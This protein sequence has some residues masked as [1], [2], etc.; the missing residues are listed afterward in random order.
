MSNSKPWLKN[1]PL[2]VPQEI[3]APS[4]SSLADFFEECFERYANRQAVESMGKF[5]TYR[6]LDSLSQEFASY[7]RTLGL[8]R[9][10]RVALMYPNV[11]EY[12]I[13][14]IGTLRAGYTV[15]NINPLYTARELEAQLQDSGASVL[16]LMEN[17]A[18]TYQQIA[19]QVPL[20]QVIVSSPGELLGL[21]GHIV[22]WVARNIKKMVPPW[23]FD[24]V[25]FKEALRIGGQYPF[26][27]PVIGLDDIAFLQYTGGTTGTSK[28]AIL[29][30][31]NILSNVMQVETWLNPGLKHRNEQQLHFLCALPMTH[32]FALTACAFLGITKGALLVLVANPRDIDGFIKM[33]MK[34]PK[35]NIFP[36]VNTLFHAL[37]HRPEF[38]KVKLP[39]LLVT[40]G[41][42]MAVHKKTAD[43]WQ[44]IT[45]CSIAQG[46][47][48]SETSPVVC[49]NSPLEKHFT[50]HIG[51]PMPSTDVVILD[52]DEVELLQGTPGEICIKGPQVMPGY[53]NK[54][55]ET[56]HCMTADGYFKSGDIGLITPEGHI[57]IVDR[58]KDMIVVAGFKVFPNDVEDVLVQM[59]GIKECAVI[60]VPHRKL[61]EIVKA[62]VVKSNHHIAESDV[63]QYCK[64]HLTSY[65][66]PRKVVFIHELPKSNVGKILRRELRNI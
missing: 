19:E 12:V 35:I 33:L 18:N 7:L 55:E 65:K 51:M 61:G 20:K 58:K 6:Q 50:G 26:Q 47:G 56:S 28:G 27:K 38:K 37:I 53:W 43:H 1:Y 41:G 30:H 42:G 60:G 54:P 66:R 57:Q 21:K 17:F 46:Y 44:A 14:M 31:R 40:I 24:H 52:D 45:G 48:L 3:G 63:L 36:G 39:N 32:I 64:E 5:F 49:V 15:V 10:A 4:H 16:V 62:Y 59:P 34:H 8:E 11:I 23:N 9:G 22:N 25:K 2:D 29:L 13:A